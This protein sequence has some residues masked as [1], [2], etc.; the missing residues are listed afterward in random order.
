[1][2]Q[3]RASLATAPSETVRLA[4][5]G[6]AAL[7][8]EPD[9]RSVE[10]AFL[11]GWAHQGLEQFAEAEVAYRQATELAQRSGTETFDLRILRQ[12]AFCLRRLGDYKNA[13]PLLEAVLQHVREAGDDSGAA[14]TLNELGIL[15]MQS[16][17]VESAIACWRDA[18]MHFESVDDLASASLV[19]GNLGIVFGDLGQ[20][21][22]SVTCIERSMELA[23]AAQGGA[24]RALNLVNLVDAYRG[25]GEDELALTLI[26]E[27]VALLE[28]SDSDYDL[29]GALSHE[30][31]IYHDRGQHHRA[32]EVL[33]RVHKIHERLGLDP[34]RA[35]T[36]AQIARVLVALERTE[37]AV[38]L[39][40]ESY[41]LSKGIES[42]NVELHALNAL[43]ASWE[44]SGDHVAALSYRE[45]AHEL[46]SQLS[47]EESRRQLEQVYAELEVQRREKELMQKETAFAQRAIE[48]KL[49]AAGFFAALAAC[50]AGWYV[51][52]LRRRTHRKLMESFG[53]LQAAHAQL[54]SRESELEAALSQIERLEG[55]L[56][57]CSLCKS[58]RS[59]DGEWSSLESYFFHRSDVRFSH[60]YC[61]TCYDKVSN[62]LQ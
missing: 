43:S 44:A 23:D 27:A 19:L 60:G 35:R 21:A 26:T 34:E 28:G 32:L 11:I 24:S 20:N 49:L 15:Y 38:E 9:E 61:P 52:L 7:G 4:T 55:L 25:L 3:A 2:A 42:L 12:R 8:D 62:D 39:S 40:Q 33:M 13:L 1:M 50:V 37:E 17:K 57:I 56:P 10:L 22:E 18:I 54:L 31:L 48:R 53:A 59:T 30:G 14:R 36:R 58:I 41:E 29:A 47:S 5:E 46:E 51:V 16:G 6:L 45:R